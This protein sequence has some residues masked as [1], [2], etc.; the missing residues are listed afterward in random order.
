MLYILTSTALAS[1]EL[2]SMFSDCVSM[3][4]AEGR[5]KSNNH[6][7]L[8]CRDSTFSFTYQPNR[9]TNGKKFSLYDTEPA[10]VHRYVTKVGVSRG[11]FSMGR[12]PVGIAGAP[13]STGF[14]TIP[15]GYSF[16]RP[17]SYIQPKSPCRY[18]M[19]LT[20]YLRWS[21]QMMPIFF[22]RLVETTKNI[23]STSHYRNFHRE[24]V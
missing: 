13:G 7:F 16:K 8:S 17:Y 12:L 10:C 2:D 5:D 14:S 3:Q 22:E 11:C 15:C 4:M 1:F 18:W 23:Q 20:G 19:G 21:L 9:S 6:H 24:T